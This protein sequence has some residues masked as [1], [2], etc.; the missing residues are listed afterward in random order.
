MLKEIILRLKKDREW[1]EWIVQWIENG[2]VND[3]KSYHTSDLE[4]ASGTMKLMVKE[5]ESKG[6]KVIKSRE[7]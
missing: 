1:G 2:R 6:Y 5:A 4:D 3:R 7:G